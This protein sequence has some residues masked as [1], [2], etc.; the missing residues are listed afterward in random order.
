MRIEQTLTNV[1]CQSPIRK[2]FVL[3]SLTLYSKPWGILWK[4]LTTVVFP[5]IRIMMVS[6]IS[7]HPSFSVLMCELYQIRHLSLHTSILVLVFRQIGINPLYQPSYSFLQYKQI[8][9]IDWIK[10]ERMKKKKHLMRII[11]TQSLEHS[12]I[13]RFSLYIYC[14]SE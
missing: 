2:F 12:S 10:I 6:S 11:R 3:L 14:S 7:F 4:S 9:L 13:R 8:I 5:M 1:S